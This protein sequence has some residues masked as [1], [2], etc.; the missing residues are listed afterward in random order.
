MDRKLKDVL[1]FSLFWEVNRCYA[2]YMFE[3]IW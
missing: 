1:R 3:N 2:G